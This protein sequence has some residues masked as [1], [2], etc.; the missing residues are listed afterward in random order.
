MH[1]HTPYATA[2]GCLEDPS[3]IM[4]HQNSCRCDI[5][6]FIILILDKISKVINFVN[7]QVSEEMCLGHW[8]PASHHGGGGGE[9]GAGAG[10]QGHTLHVS[11]R[12]PG[13]C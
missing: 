9:A 13:H 8:I 5:L 6:T 2:L 10:G 1:T 11:P 4:V 3:L 12:H 7:I